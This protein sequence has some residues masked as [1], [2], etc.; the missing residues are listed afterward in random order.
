MKTY[1]VKSCIGENCITQLDGEAIHDLIHPALVSNESVELDFGGCT[2]FASLFFNHAI[3]KLLG[4]FQPDQL[5]KMLSV[6]NLTPDA[7]S[8]LT[9]VIENAKRYYGDPKVREA[10]DKAIAEQADKELDGG[11]ER[12]GE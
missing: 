10:Q 12:E 9:R 6:V 2:V 5:N 1:S 11:E 7:M 8:I 4:E 3:G